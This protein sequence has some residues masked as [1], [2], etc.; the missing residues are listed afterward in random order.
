M[1]FVHGKSASVTIVDATPASRD[2]SSY[3]NK[4][5]IDRS[6][7]LADVSTFGVNAHAYLPGLQDNQ[8]P[9]DGIYDSTGVT[10]LQSVFNAGTATTF[11]YGPAGTVTTNVK[12]SGTAILETLKITGAV[13]DAIQISASLRVTGPVTSGT[14]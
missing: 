14:Y 13:N 9:L 5:E 6:F 3:L 1:A 12:F 7:D 4:A 10:Y 8:I 2:I 11:T